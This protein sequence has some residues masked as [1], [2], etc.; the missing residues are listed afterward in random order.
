MRIPFF[1][2]KRGGKRTRPI[3]FTYANGIA[4]DEMSEAYKNFEELQKTTEN[5]F[6]RIEF[7]DTK[8]AEIALMFVRWYLVF[9]A[10]VIVGVPLFNA[11]AVDGNETIDIYKVLAQLGT[12]LGS[13]LGFV[14]G[15][16]FK[17]DKDKD[18]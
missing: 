1:N 11:F 17:D 4:S 10:L 15:Y 14:V 9:V 7:M 8:R 12:L 3:V 2:R 16:Y 13:P 5:A 6:N 18:S